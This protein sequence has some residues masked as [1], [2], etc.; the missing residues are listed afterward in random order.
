MKNVIY[1][2]CGLLCD[3]VVWE[4]QAAALRPEYDVR[5]L[6]FEGLDS[7]GAMAEKVLADAPERFALAGHS[8]GG[9]VALEVVRR[10]PQRVE[11]L[12]LLDTG[13]E[14]AAPGEAEKRAVLVDQAL[15]EGIGSIAASWGLPMLAPANR[16]NPALVRA[17]VEMVGRMSGE[18]YAGKT[19][20]LLGR[21]DATGVLQSI[22]CPTMIICGREDGWSPPERHERM[23][24]LVPHAQL[25]LIEGAGH[26]TMME[27]PEAI[28]QALREWLALPITTYE[29][30]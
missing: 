17:V 2:L 28:L 18:I 24:A 26:M 5:V 3:S 29:E 27:A 19:R 10:A 21:P 12:A 23:A 11:R 25:R 20:A 30:T 16:D 4:A 8:M 13:Y 1:L 6:S 7:M 9:R 14:P 15:T 22:A